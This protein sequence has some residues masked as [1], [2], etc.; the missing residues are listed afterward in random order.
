MVVVVVAGDVDGGCGGGDGCCCP[1]LCALLL[2]YRNSAGWFT[3]NTFHMDLA[4][5]GRDAHELSRAQPF[6][7]SSPFPAPR[8]LF[9]VRRRL[10]PCC[11][12]RGKVVATALTGDPDLYVTV[13]GSDLPGPQNF[14][15]M[16]GATGE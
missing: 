12:V 2:L 4:E 11:V 16:G 14:Y 15:W 13:G 5:T 10:L 1:V 6:F 3:T 7:S 8:H 9:F